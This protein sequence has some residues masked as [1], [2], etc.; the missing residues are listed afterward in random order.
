VGLQAQ[1]F[2]NSDSRPTLQ[3]AARR[4]I[5]AAF[6]HSLDEQRAVSI[7]AIRCLHLP[8]RLPAGPGCPPRTLRWASR[9]RGEQPI[10]RSYR[11]AAS[12]P[13]RRR[14]VKLRPYP[15]LHDQALDRSG[16]SNLRP[17][18]QGTISSDQLPPVSFLDHFTSR[19]R[20]MTTSPSCTRFTIASSPVSLCPPRQST[21]SA[22]DPGMTS[23]R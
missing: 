11:P 13:F 1:R 21:N 19:L 23:A 18:S 4:G 7:S 5:P 8:R 10:S 6:H 14:L 3:A 12:T 20:H 22:A 16:C 2:R 17:S 15:D 9:P